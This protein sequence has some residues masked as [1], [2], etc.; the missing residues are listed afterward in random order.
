MSASERFTPSFR[1][2]G[3]TG[4]RDY[5]QLNH[6]PKINEVELEGE[7]TDEDL[8]LQ[9]KMNRLTDQDIDKILYGGN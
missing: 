2:G 7:L 6:K 5:R 3:T 4:T 8:S 1:G 9:H